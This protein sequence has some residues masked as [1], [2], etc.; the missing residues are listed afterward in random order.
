M[1]HRIQNH[2]KRPATTKRNATKINL[3]ITTLLASISR[4]DDVVDEEPPDDHVRRLAASF[5][6][7]LLPL[8]LVVLPLYICCVCVFVCVVWTKYSLFKYGE[9]CPVIID[10]IV[11]E[12]CLWCD[13]QFCHGVEQPSNIVL[14]KPACLDLVQISKFETR[15][16]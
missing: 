10:A 11:D 14:I 3:P 5:F 8:L 7:V 12:K 2:P 13:C 1:F 16:T 15:L 6:L 4:K 9:V